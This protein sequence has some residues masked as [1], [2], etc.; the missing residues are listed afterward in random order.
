[1]NGTIDNADNYKKTWARREKFLKDGGGKKSDITF[2]CVVAILS[3]YFL[4]CR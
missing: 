3:R 4:S 2:F 1:V